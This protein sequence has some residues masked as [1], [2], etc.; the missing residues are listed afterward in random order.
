VACNVHYPFDKHGFGEAKF[1][2]GGMNW[3]ITGRCGPEGD[4]WRVAYG[5]TPGMTD[6]WLWENA[7][8]R[9]KAILPGSEPFKIVQA[10]QYRVHQRQVKTYKVGRVVVAGDAA[11]LNNPIGGFG[12]TTGMTDAGCI[13]ESL[14]LINETKPESF[15]QAACDMRWRIFRAIQALN[16]LKQLSSRTRIISVRSFWV[17][18]GSSEKMR[19]SKRRVCSG[20]WRSIHQ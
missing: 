16:G 12:L 13:A 4:P 1:P 10:A 20:R 17:S 15:L 7:E 5:I 3:A 6:E 14:G 9:V 2:I 19:L 18:S 8:E 11:H